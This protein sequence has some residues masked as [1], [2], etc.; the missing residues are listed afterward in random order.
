MVAMVRRWSVAESIEAR[1]FET[2][3]PTSRRFRRGE[4]QGRG[5]AHA[6]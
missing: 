4:M 2:V 6:A 1:S 5:K 3:E